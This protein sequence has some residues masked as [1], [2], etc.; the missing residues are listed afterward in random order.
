MLSVQHT[1]ANTVQLQDLF[2]L[3]IIMQNSGID[4]YGIAGIAGQE[5]TL[6]MLLSPLHGNPHR[7]E[8]LVMCR[9][10]SSS[11]CLMWTGMV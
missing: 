2:V 10:A 9:T 3:P 1:T 7:F 8:T 4:Q 6:L 5:F 11:R